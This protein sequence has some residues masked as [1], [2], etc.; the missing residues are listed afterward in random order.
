MDLRAR[1]EETAAMSR[2]NIRILRFT[3]GTYPCATHSN[4]PWNRL[5][6]IE[7]SRP[8]L[9]CFHDGARRVDAEPGCWYVMPCD[10][11]TG[12][13]L[14]PETEFV[15]VQF[16]VE[17]FRGVDL[18]S[19]LAGVPCG[20]NPELV[21]SAAAA[22]EQPDVLGA[23]AEIKAILYRVLSG[24]LKELKRPPGGGLGDW[25]RYR[26][27][28]PLLSEKA[29]ARLTVALLADRL[30]MRG[31]VFSRRFTR[32]MGLSPKKFLSRL[33]LGQALEALA[34]TDRGVYEIA[35]Q[36]GF[37]NEFYFS[38][39]VRK[40]TGFPPRHHRGLSRM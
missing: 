21:R 8:G 29:P 14:H 31:D 13:E 1:N 2:L 11:T 19:G 10:R 22:F 17:L 18:L 24:T 26:P 9:S 32:D 38:R 6:L 25:E 12:L 15:S 39:F 5:L 30:N 35:R 37:A 28:L 27:I 4:Y 34:N 3:R 40:H 7:K 33:L 16:Y 23:A 36:L 20:R